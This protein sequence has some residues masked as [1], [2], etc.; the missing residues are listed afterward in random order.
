MIEPRTH[1]GGGSLAAANI[2]PAEMA[3]NVIGVEAL[4]HEHA[5]KTVRFLRWMGLRG[6]DVDDALQEIFLTAH[7]RGGFTVGTAQPFTWLT[8]IA[9]NVVRSRRRIRRRHPEEPSE[10]LDFQIDERDPEKHSETMQSL[11]L[12]EQALDALDFDK[13]SL[14]VLLEIEGR[15]YEEVART[16]DIDLRT[17]YVRV[18]RAK[19]EFIA[20]FERLESNSPRTK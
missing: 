10:R 16:L 6:P 12:V 20:A 4:F 14:V 11:A 18:H 5:E 3:T 8:R 17:L 13:R 1:D 7:R 9:V 19:K 15:S 2:I